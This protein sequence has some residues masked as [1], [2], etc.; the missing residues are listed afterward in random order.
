[1]QN[2]KPIIISAEKTETADAVFY[3]F[4]I[5]M[6]LVLPPEVTIVC[7]QDDIESDERPKS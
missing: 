4:K 5:R 3:K 7:I 6:P 1:M 2:D